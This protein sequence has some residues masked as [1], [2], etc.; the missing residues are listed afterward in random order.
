[1]QRTLGLLRN[2][3]SVRCSAAARS[4]RLS[5]S[6]NYASVTALDGLPRPGERIHGFSLE[7][8][9]HVPE[10]E[11]TA[12]EF[13]HE[14]TG[15][16]YLHIARDDQN[17]V[18]SIGFKTNP[19]DAT[20][21]PHILE[22]TTLCGSD[23][24][25]VRDPF[26]KMLPRSLSNFMNAFT[27]SDHTTYP[28]ATT[29]AQDFKNLMS[30]Y[31]DA[32]LRPLLKEHDYT[33]EGWRLGPVD[34]LGNDAE[35]NSIIFKGVVYNEMKGQ[36]SDASY[37][38]Y[39]RF[40]E[41]L[42]PSINNSGGDPQKMTDL[43]YEQLKTFHQEHYH[44]S[45]AK[46][47]T[48]GNL[49]LQSHLESINQ[50]LAGFSAIK[51]DLDIKIPKS[52]K[53]G[54]HEVTLKGPVDPLAPLD[55]QNKTSVSWLMGETSDVVENFSLSLIASLL[56]DGYGSPLYQNLIETGL[57]TDYSPNSGYDGS[58]KRAV[59]SVGLNGVKQENIPKVKAAIFETLRNVR[60][61]GFEAQKVEGM[62]HQLELSLKHKTANFGMAIMQRLYPSW[63]NGVD[64]FDALAW[65]RTVDAFKAEYAKGEY[66]ENL[67]DK[68]LLTDDIMLFTMQP[69]ETYA[70]ELAAEES[71]R[72]EAKKAEAYE[73]LGGQEKATERLREREV[74]LVAQQS[75]EQD[76][77]CLPMVNVSDI[78]RRKAITRSLEKRTSGAKTL[79]REAATNG[80][81]YFRGLSV[82]K[83]LPNELRPLIPLFCDALMRIGTKTKSMEEIEDLIKLKTGGVSFGYHA[84]SS[85][86]NP[87]EY[88][89]GISLSGYAFDQNIPAMY[90]LLHL[91]IQDT[92]FDSPKGHRMVTELVQS[93]ASGAVDGVAEAG[94][95]YARRFAE[96]GISSHAQL[97]EQT[98]GVTQVAN[99]STLAAHPELQT[100]IASTLLQAF[101]AIQAT[102]IS[103]LPST[104]IALTCSP[105]AVSQNTSALE[106]FLSTTFTTQGSTFAPGLTLPIRD[107]RSSITNN[108][109]T[110]FPLP[111]QVSYSA[112]S[113]KTV[114]YTD[115]A[116]A[117]LAILAQLLTHKHLHREIREKG[118]AYGGG[119]YS[120]ALDGLFGYYSY[121]DPNPANTM[122]V[123][124]GAGKWAAERRWTETDLQEAKLSIFQSVDAPKAVSEEGMV[125]FV[126]GVTPEMEQQRRERLLDVTAEQVRD[127]A[128]RFLVDGAAKAR[129]AVLGQRKEFMSE[130]KGWKVEDLGMGKDVTEA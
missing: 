19:P 121:R 5:P 125:E 46:I 53:G 123:V 57:G 60:Q 82:V 98:S 65:Q 72:L 22:H 44:P 34:P 68:Y 8:S 6:R 130:K 14:G 97:V 120:K 126:T 52:L 64:V 115:P 26:F 23:K 30:V 63:F 85:A 87:L 25:P 37:L 86:T 67:M 124:D 4:A 109:K 79:L 116:S 50:Q 76:L 102:L 106:R 96:A 55:S 31:M 39:I 78:A 112:A 13:R 90:D 15:A 129:V 117:P 101:K 127:V 7:R 75:A 20:G 108:V 71:E 16:H 21:V 128:E 27:S 45:N 43:T 77:A 94:H 18:F 28:F 2:D 41:H 54:P 62:L 107:W 49:P 91:L 113:I 58:S 9:K 100:T 80:I 111:Y 42:F 92:D 103:S 61:K 99:I 114:P 119:A 33:Q 10:L 110:L 93:A 59:F 38:F 24:Y 17:N 95:A 51:P 48:Y 47:L 35:A 118:G 88:E 32:T 89:E 3:A 12:L 83:N 36:M 104:R 81:T 74:E 70:A 29:N 11:L 56:M 66:F 105:E 122:N 84:T 73:M 40:Y 69:S 1:M